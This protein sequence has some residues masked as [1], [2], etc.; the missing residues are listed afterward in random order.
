MNIAK[1]DKFVTSPAVGLRVNFPHPFQKKVERHENHNFY[2]LSTLGFI[3]ICS[4]DRIS[5]PR[6][7]SL[8]PTSTCFLLI[9]SGVLFYKVFRLKFE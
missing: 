3:R 4:L 6:F 2:F 9:F 7:W 1:V 8:V 5:V